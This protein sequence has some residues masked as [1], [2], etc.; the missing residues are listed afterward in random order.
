ML[1]EQGCDVIKLE[2]F[3]GIYQQEKIF[4]MRENLS[5]GRMTKFL[6]RNGLVLRRSTNVCQKLPSKYVEKIPRILFMSGPCE[7]VLG[8]LTT[9]L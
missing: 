1:P 8:I 9:V 5:H 2:K 3:M 4:T 7:T 6:A